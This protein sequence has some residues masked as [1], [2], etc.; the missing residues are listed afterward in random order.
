MELI[1]Q[2]SGNQPLQISSLSFE[3]PGAGF[4]LESRTRDQLIDPGM[5]QSISI[6]FLPLSIGPH[7]NTLLIQSNSLFTPIFSV[8]LS[9]YGI[10]GSGSVPSNIQLQV[11]G[12]DVHLSWNPVVSDPEGNPFTP[13][14]YVILYSENADTDTGNYFYHGFTQQTSYVHA[15]VVRHRNKMFYRIIAIDANTRFRI[16]N[17]LTGEKQLQFLSWSEIKTRLR[18]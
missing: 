7:T 6:S 5:S 15:G 16:E 12:D 13:S 9:G 2:N 14:E 10:D 17:M 1:L 4:T 3:T 11:I 18:N 8:P